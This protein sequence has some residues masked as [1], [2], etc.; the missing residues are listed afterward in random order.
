METIKVKCPLGYMEY[1][2]EELEQEISDLDF[3]RDA[4]L[5]LLNEEVVSKSDIPY[6]KD[7]VM[8][9]AKEMYIESNYSNEFIEKCFE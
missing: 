9:Y 6:S 7:E 4:F 1:T 2:K 3:L 8:K 5:V